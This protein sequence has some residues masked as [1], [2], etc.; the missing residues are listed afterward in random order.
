MRKRMLLAAGL[1]AAAVVLSGAEGGASQGKE[2]FMKRCSGCHSPDRD[3]EGPHL[4]G[5][6]WR[7]SGSVP[8][9]PYSERL[10]QAG[11]TWDAQSLDRWLTDPDALVPGNDM[12]LRTEK[13]EERAEIIRYLRQ[14][15]PDAK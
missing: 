11:I 15:S 10:K 7:R 5:V 2:L 12:S 3:M 9:F 14:L 1:W 8:G 6:Y 13:A 4:R